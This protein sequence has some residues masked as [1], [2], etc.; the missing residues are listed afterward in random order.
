M[1]KNMMKMDDMPMPKEMKKM[2]KEKMKGSKKKSDMMKKCM[3]HMEELVKVNKQIL[4]ELKK[5]NKKK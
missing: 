2:M 3:G 1:T 5:L 4:V